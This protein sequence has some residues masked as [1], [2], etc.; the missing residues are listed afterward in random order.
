MKRS[1][2]I[3]GL[4][5]VWM[6]LLFAG[7]SQGASDIPA[8][9]DARDSSERARVQAL[10][11]GA[12]K[13]NKLD[14]TGTMVEPKHA[15]HVI[16]GLKEYYGLPNLKLN[17]TYGL[18]TEILARAEEVLKA[19]R[20]PPDIV[21]MVAWDWYVDLIKRGKLMRYDSPYYREYTLSDK[22]GNSM[23]G[24]WVSDAYTSNPMWNL[25]ELQKRGMKDFNPSSWWDFA[26]PKLIPHTALVNIV[27]SSSAPAWAI[28]MRKAVGDD[29]FIKLAKG[30]PAVC[31]KSEQGERW[32][33]SGEYP[34]YLT[35]RTKSAQELYDGGIEVRLLW[36]KEGQVLFPFAAVVLGDAPHPNSAKLFIDYVRSASGASRMAETGVGLIYGRPGVK[37][38]EKER[39]FLPPAETIK[40]I[41]MDWNKDTT[42]EAVQALR[43]WARKVEI[44][45]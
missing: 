28:G 6:V 44:G 26:D 25:K 45:Y 43:Q 22:A 30:K 36:P 42:K 5:A 27:T 4:G 14:W 18:G 15:N 38:P 21:W 11:D 33:A 3:S 7:M 39:R 2:I 13:E 23:P 35:A 9:R 12:Q 20:T 8:V 41:P 1:A 34:I 16:A 32:V 37:I 10:I 17:Y 31:A 19:G 24:Y 29:W 40:A